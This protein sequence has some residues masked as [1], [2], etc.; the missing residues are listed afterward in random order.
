MFNTPLS[1]VTYD[2][3]IA[4][5]RTFAEGVRV[6][7]KREVVNTPKVVSSFANTVGGIWVI[8]VE[9]D[10]KTNLPILPPIGMDEL[11]GIEERIVQSAQ[12]GIYLPITP[13]VRV[14]PIP[15]QKGRVVVI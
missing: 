10:K 13:A 1:Q 7:Y 15:Q 14:L 3:V 2:D 5:C 4:F 8:G 12:S 11:S 6:E 9:T